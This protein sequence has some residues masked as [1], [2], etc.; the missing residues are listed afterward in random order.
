MAT[1]TPTAEIEKGLRGQAKFVTSLHVR[2]HRVTF[3]ISNTL[4]KPIIRP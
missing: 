4:T 1:Q 3:Y 2:M